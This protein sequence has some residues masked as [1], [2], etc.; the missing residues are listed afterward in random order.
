[1]IL[2]FKMKISL[3]KKAYMWFSDLAT[4]PI[5]QQIFFDSML[6]IMLG[7]YTSDEDDGQRLLSHGTFSLVKKADI[8]I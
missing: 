1:M 3:R 4:Y 5:I 7:I 6:G 2:F 8:E